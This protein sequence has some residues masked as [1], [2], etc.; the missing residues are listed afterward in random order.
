M[1]TTE[2]TARTGSN[3]NVRY[4]IIGALVIGAFFGAYRFASARNAEP[5]GQTG[6][7]LVQAGTPAAG[8]PAATA[9]GGDS[10]CGGTPP[11]GGISGELVEGTAEVAGD[12]QKIDVDLSQGYYQP[13]QIVLKAGVPTEIT[14]GQ[15]SGCTGQVTSEELGFLEELSA[16]PRTVKLPALEVGEYPFY[17]GMK[18]VYGKIVVK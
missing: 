12:V 14:F 11:E 16:G 6:A 2:N 9:A 5:T 8:D 3:N 15:S 4:L 18:M 17:C 7:Q 10:C 1:S 13:N